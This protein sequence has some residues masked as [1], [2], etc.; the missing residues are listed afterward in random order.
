MDLFLRV[1]AELGNEFLDPT[2]ALP[3]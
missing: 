3:D 2:G 1:C